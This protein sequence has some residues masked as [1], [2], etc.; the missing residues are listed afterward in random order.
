MENSEENPKKQQKDLF[1]KQQQ[2]RLQNIT[3]KNNLSADDLIR[4]ILEKVDS[5]A[6]ISKLCVPQQQRSQQPGKLPLFLLIFANFLKI[7]L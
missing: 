1:Y 7:L 6:K 2:Q 4:N 5:D 3:L